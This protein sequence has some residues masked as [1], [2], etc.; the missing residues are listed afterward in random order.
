MF[1]ISLTW[2]LNIW[3]IYRFLLEQYNLV[4]FV[5]WVIACIFIF[6]IRQNN[7]MFK[8]CGVWPFMCYHICS[9]FFLNLTFFPSI[10]NCDFGPM[11]DFCHLRFLNNAWHRCRLLLYSLTSAF[12]G[13]LFL[14]V[15]FALKGISNWML[16]QF[17]FYQIYVNQ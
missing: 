10:C 1:L 16:Y 14:Q 5:I 15:H 11:N 4:L 6:R 2:M 17:S 9:F 7:A 12:I 13:L 8:L 3:I